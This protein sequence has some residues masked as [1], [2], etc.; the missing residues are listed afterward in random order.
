MMSLLRLLVLFGFVMS[1]PAMT[2]SAPAA[3][4]TVIAHRGA[5]GYLPEHTIA[6]KAMAYGMGADFIEQDLVLT[7]DGVP[8]VLHD[9]HL[10]TVTD[11]AERFP[12]RKREDGRFYAIDLT[13]AEI[14][15]LRVFERFNRETGK[16]VF[17][18]RFGN[19]DVR[20]T[21]PTF[22]E[23]IALI[24]GLNAATGREVGIYPEIKAPGFHRAEGKD[25]SRIVVEILNKHGLSSKADPVI[26]QCFDWNETQ[27]IRDELGYGGRLV[28]L[29]AEN[30][31]NIAAG[32]DFDALK[33]AE[34]LAMIAKVAEGIGPWI[35]QVISGRAED[36][37]LTVTSLVVDAHAAG[38]VVH[39]YT[40]RSDGLPDWAK[41]MDDLLEGV[42]MTAGADGIFTD[43]PDTAVSFVGNKK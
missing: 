31:W 41:T 14:K 32:V 19:K 15:T 25:I 17:P 1:V 42:L 28:Q 6:A 39:P 37:K 16:R 40:A 8:I 9:I 38:L 27:R 22:E 26:V 3:E 29:I 7:R 5:S 30:K 43:F 35:P 20:F 34:G 23:E 21:V 2:G 11:V 33:T 18:N 24:K 13:L 4:K 10:D 12:D 36:G